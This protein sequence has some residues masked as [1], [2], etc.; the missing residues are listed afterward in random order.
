MDSCLDE[1]FAGEAL[2]CTGI[3]LLC[4]QEFAEDR[5]TMSAVVFMLGN[6]SALPT[7]KQP[8]FV[9]KR[10]TYTSGDP[11][12]SEGANSINDVTCSIVEAR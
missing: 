8:A 11:S 6:D 7:P 1:S 10:S 4:L 9:F 12:T 3:G 2:R 5:P